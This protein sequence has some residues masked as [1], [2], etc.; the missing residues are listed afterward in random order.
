[1]KIL[2]LS[3]L[4]GLGLSL[5]ACVTVNAP[6]G[7]SDNNGVITKYPIETVMLNIYT[8]ERY[9]TLY[10]LDEADLERQYKIIVIKVTPKGVISFDDNQRQATDI[11]YMRIHNE[12]MI[13]RSLSTNYFSLDPLRFYGFTNSFEDY[14]LATQIASI[15]KMAT[16]G[17]SNEFITENI[18]SD[19]SKR[20]QIGQY[21]QSWSLAKDSNNTAL[22]CINTSPNTFDDADYYDTSSH[23]YR[24]NAKGDILSSEL[25]NK[26]FSQYGN[27]TT[28][29][30]SR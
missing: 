2:G 14:S 18:Y 20:E 30:V 6:M 21:N 15:P 5:S 16:V 8:R 10:S 22:F 17:D 19:S 12:D 25:T 27:D 24:I 1:M 3:L 28:K 23:C 4:A 9:E 13:D 29:Y 26:T 7:T 11:S